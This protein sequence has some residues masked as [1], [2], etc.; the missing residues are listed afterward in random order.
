MNNVALVVAPPAATGNSAAPTITITG[1]ANNDTIN[2]S[3]TTG[4]DSVTMGAGESALGGSGADVFLV[5]AST[6]SDAIN[7]GTGGAELYFSGGG[8]VAL[9]SNITNIA[10]LYLAKATSAYTAMAN[11]ISGLTV[12]DAST[13]TTDTLTAGGANQTLTGGGPGKVTMVG[14]LDTTFKDSAA[15]FKGDTIQN[16]LAGDHIDV[17]GLGFTVAGTAA[18]QM[19]LGFAA[20]GSN[21]TVSVYLGSTL[22]TLFT[23]SGSIDH[24]GFTAGADAA[25]TGTLLRYNG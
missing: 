12:Q 20:N 5:T 8:V 15:V 14:A 17:T 25:G 22:E 9:G 1:A 19:N 10:T 13:T 24:S 16:L 3:S 23:V 11:G 18:G 4:A 2:L 6:I 7:G 21:T